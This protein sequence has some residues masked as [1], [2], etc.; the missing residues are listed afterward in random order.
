MKRLLPILLV[1]ALLTSCG[2]VKKTLGMEK[3]VP[4]EFA[5]VERAPLTMPPNF[6]LTP[7]EPG[8]P[9]PQEAAISSDAQS[10]VLGSQSSAP[11]AETGSAI[12]RSLLQQA[13]AANVSPSIRQ[14]LAQPDLEPQEESVA[15]KLGISPSNERGK[16]LNPTEEAQRLQQKNVKTTPVKP[17]QNAE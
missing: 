10:L 15:Q 13:G 7:P 16:A 2:G 17:V 5:V 9:R 3:T 6:G 11:K 4:D 14:E 8:A 12:E 1:P